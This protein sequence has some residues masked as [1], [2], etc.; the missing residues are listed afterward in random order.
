MVRIV[1]LIVSL[2]LVY[3]TV[4]FALIQSDDWSPCGAAADPGGS[5]AVGGSAVG[6][7]KGQGKAA[8]SV[9]F[10]GGSVTHRDPTPAE[11]P[12]LW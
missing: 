9:F 5:S 4:L 7:V 8:S 1:L 11:T 6:G 3:F 2:I 12:P 10:T